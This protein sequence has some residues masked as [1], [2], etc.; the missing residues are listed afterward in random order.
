MGNFRDRMLIYVVFMVLLLAGGPGCASGQKMV[1]MDNQESR[2]GMLSEQELLRKVED[3]AKTEFGDK[4]DTR[5]KETVGK[6]KRMSVQEYLELLEEKNSPG[7]YR[8][9]PGD[10]LRITV[11]EDKALSL[12]SA[13][14]SAEG[15]IQYPLLGTLE[16]AGKT[17]SEIQNMISG[18]LKEMDF[19]VNP[20]VSVKI[21][22]YNSQQVVLLGAV[23]RPGSYALKKEETLLGMLSNAGGIREQEAGQHLI[24]IRQE[25]EL[26]GKPKIAVQIPLSDLLGSTD[27]PANLRV[28]ADDTVYIPS[29]SKF[30]VIGQVQKP[31]GY[32][33]KNSTSVAEAISMAGGF[34]SIAAPNRVH[35]TRMA[36]NQKKVIRVNVKKMIND[37]PDHLD[38]TVQ[39]NDLIVVPESYF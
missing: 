7:E 18:K 15:V 26:E 37:G 12:D 11:Y 19:L 14:I 21:T 9:G 8:T 6:A 25:D 5:F 4:V 17:V 27:Q 30:F 10:V 36:Q 24:L 20:H 3:P 13:R 22:D 38:V 29:A 28:Q 34:T 32:I 35:I 2:S 39:P 23:H 1:Y 16:V 31:G 33:L